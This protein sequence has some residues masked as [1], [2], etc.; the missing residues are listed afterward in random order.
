[1]KMVF[2]AAGIF[3]PVYDRGIDDE[4]IMRKMRKMKKKLII[5]IIFS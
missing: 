5:L 1:M 2:S 4:K 3:H